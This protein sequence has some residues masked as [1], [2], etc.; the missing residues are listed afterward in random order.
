M[1][2]AIQLREEEDLE[3]MLAFARN[4]GFSHVALGFGSSDIFMKEDYKRRVEEISDLL[5]KNDLSCIQTHLPCYHLLVDSDECDEKIELAIKR[6]IEESATLGA[7]W[8][9]FHPRSAV[10]SG[11]DRTKA[12][13]DNYEKLKEY[14]EYAEKSGVG[15]AVEN[16][17]LYPFSHPE[18]RFFGGGFEEL[19]ELCDDFKSDKIG[20]C[21]D[22][23]HAHISALDMKN[24]LLTVGDRLKITHVHDN[25]RNGD[26][27]QLPLMSD[28]I[29][30]GIDW[31]NAVSSLSDVNYDG[32]LTLE[33]ITP[34][35][36]MRKSFLMQCYD[37][38]CCL[39]EM[40]HERKEEFL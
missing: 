5:L 21:W 38:L 4:A 8:T 6:C 10:K 13:A 39:E 35:K 19:C 18:W 30:G 24:A 36:A 34:P 32:P 29:W 1:I 25:Y 9:A 2:K 14:L 12:Y 28:P 31:S 7:K 17:P 11:Y 16:M 27:H 37:C 26:H 23:G 20:I 22:F 15:I 3:E 33:L 40:S